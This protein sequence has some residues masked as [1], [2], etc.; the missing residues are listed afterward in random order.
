MQTYILLACDRLEE[1]Q[2]KKLIANLPEIKQALYRYAEEQG[3]DL[4]KIID[5][6]DSEHCEDWQLGIEQPIKKSK[7][8]QTPINFFN[9][10]GKEFKLDF[11]IGSVENDKREAVSYFGF[12]EGHGDPFMIA[13]YLDL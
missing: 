5:N 12:E 4:V 8:L 6:S 1:P 13:Q 7:Q 9:D 3:L 11:E 10:L 2:E